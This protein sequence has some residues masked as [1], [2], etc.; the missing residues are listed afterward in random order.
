MDAVHSGLR[1]KSACNLGCSAT[2]GAWR[3]MAEKL[4]DR[5]GLRPNVIMDEKMLMRSGTSAV[6]AVAVTLALS[7]AAFAGS[8]INVTLWDKGPDSAQPDAAHLLGM[9]SGGDMTMA[10]LGVKADVASV[11][12][13]MVTFQVTNASKDIVHEMILSPAPSDGKVLPYM[14]DMMKVDE[15]GAGHLG[16]VSELNP[17]QGGALTVD[18]KPGKYLLFCNLPAHFMNGMWT[19]ITVN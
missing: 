5:A 2:F 16:E 11:R 10:M 4:T 14:A 13:G 15:D 8:K 19:E 12:A 7:G 1:R 9:G 6:L 17:G 18:L 3:G